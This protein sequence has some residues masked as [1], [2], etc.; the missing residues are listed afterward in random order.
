MKDQAIYGNVIIVFPTATSAVFYIFQDLAE[1][2]GCAY[3]EDAVTVL[4]Q[5]LATM[6][7]LKPKPVYDCE[8]DMVSISSRSAETIFTIATV[9]N[10][11]TVAPKQMKA[12]EVERAK[13]L[14]R[15]RTWKRPQAKPWKVGDVFTVPL[16]DQ[17][18]MFGQVVGLHGTWPTCALFELRKTVEQIALDELMVSRAI[19]V[20]NTDNAGLASGNNVVVAH[21]ELLVDSKHAKQNST[22]D[23]RLLTNLGNAY[24][25]LE[26]WNRHYDERRYDKILLPH[27]VRPNTA[28]VL[29]TT[30]RAVVDKVFYWEKITDL[31]HRALNSLNCLSADQTVAL[32]KLL[33]QNELGLASEL[34]VSILKKLT[35]EPA[36]MV[37][38]YLQMVAL[39]RMHFSRV[40]AFDEMPKLA[41]ADLD[42]IVQSIQ[43][44]PD[45]YLLDKHRI[46][47]TKNKLSLVSAAEISQLIQDQTDTQDHPLVDRIIVS[48][49]LDLALVLSPGHTLSIV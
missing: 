35:I 45:F 3:Q 46:D 11:L 6:S 36:A 9:M 49:D 15:M 25:G 21:Y 38:R 4:K 28:W 5:K 44:K 7:A 48:S 16:K 29:N 10:S 33:A 17:T 2:F 24:Y 42:T 43:T 13:I 23:C 40:Q 8:A 26:P 20:I 32:K 19:A 14:Q 37:H 39:K 18:F 34:L 31:L 22:S 47:S 41:K 1:L 12:T 27:I 30:E